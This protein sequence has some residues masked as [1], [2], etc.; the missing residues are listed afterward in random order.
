MPNHKV[1]PRYCTSSNTRRR[2][3]EHTTS[4]RTPAGADQT[5]NVYH[6]YGHIHFHTSEISYATNVTNVNSNNILRNTMTETH[7]DYSRVI[8]DS[9]ARSD[10][11]RS[12][13]SRQRQKKA[14]AKASNR[15]ASAVPDELNDVVFASVNVRDVPVDRYVDV[16]TQTEPS[17]ITIDT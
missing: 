5:S 6:I 2:V 14:G 1:N 7:N 11:P 3:R 9:L 4:I 10:P 13:H 8:L 15:A 16:A 12:K 17:T